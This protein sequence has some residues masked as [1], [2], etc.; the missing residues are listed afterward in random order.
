MEDV[1]KKIEYMMSRYVMAIDNDRLEEWPDFFTDDC[2]YLITNSDNYHQGF[3]HGAIYAN[4]RGMVKDR[5]SA[6]REANIYE[7]HNYRHITSSLVI[8]E[9]GDGLVACESNFLVVRTMHDGSSGVFACGCYKDLI[10]VRGHTPLFKERIVV[11]DS[12]NFD[13]L[14][15]LPI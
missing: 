13:T 7:S 1:K 3:L 6:L 12:S 5:V 11:C 10:D 15:A 8:L 14:L 4:S 9:E 2:K